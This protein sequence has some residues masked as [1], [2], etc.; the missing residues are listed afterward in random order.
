M[1]I[2]GTAPQGTGG[3]ILQ[4]P[5]LPVRASWEMLLK[6][7]ELCAFDHLGVKLPSAHPSSGGSWGEEKCSRT[8]RFAASQP[9]PEESRAVF[10]EEGSGRPAVAG[11]L[12][13]QE[14]P[15]SAELSRAFQ[16]PTWR[17]PLPLSSPT[18]GLLSSCSLNAYLPFVP[19]NLSR[20]P[21]VTLCLGCSE[22]EIRS[23][24]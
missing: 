20:P 10:L 15:L 19:R 23:Y 22:L 1:G 8:M 18:A 11:R 13:E 9:R 6:N 2:S 4:G 7:A 24:R 3:N 5:L 12:A 14:R 16:H 21:Q 17:T